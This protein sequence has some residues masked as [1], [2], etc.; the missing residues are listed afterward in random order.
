MVIEDLKLMLFFLE[1]AAGG[2]DMNLL[3]YRKPTKIYRSD[4]CPSGM[5]G[6]SSYGFAWSF[7]IPLE[8]KF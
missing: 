4:S 6:Y 5:G 7:Y 8:F 1:E 2:V 3:L